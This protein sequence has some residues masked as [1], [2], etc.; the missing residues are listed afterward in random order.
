MAVRTSKR[1]YG[2]KEGMDILRRMT[3]KKLVFALVLVAALL[4]IALPAAAQGPRPVF[5]R[6]VGTNEDPFGGLPLFDTQKANDFS[7]KFLDPSLG[8]NAVQGGIPSDKSGDGTSPRKAVYI[9]GAWAAQ[10]PAKGFGISAGEHPQEIPSCVT[11]KVPAGQN[12]W[13]KYDSWAWAP[14]ANAI[15]GYPIF[16]QTWLDDELDGAT[17]PSGSAVFGA[18]S[19]YAYGI[20]AWDGWSSKL[21]ANGDNTGYGRDQAGTNGNWNGMAGPHS[22][23]FV[24]FVYGT[25]ILQPNYQYAAPNAFLF[26]VGVG[27]S[28][29]L[30]RSG[31][32]PPESGIS[33]SVYCNPNA[34]NG[35]PVQGVPPSMQC[36]GFG[37]V[38]YGQYWPSQ[39]SHLLFYESRFDGWNFARVLNQ[40]VWDATASVCSYRDVRKGAPGH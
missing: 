22:E 27:S 15:Q 26:T 16:T 33:T 8:S 12:R 7:A 14:A 6:A 21:D 1:F 30:N 32:V 13:F 3:M 19:Q 10:T 25:N 18:S 20:Q 17:K 28:G 29:S 11:M 37:N 36:K 31:P 24:M 34:N 40:M 38:G 2:P 4:V 5:V 35:D 39:P 9:G 23:G